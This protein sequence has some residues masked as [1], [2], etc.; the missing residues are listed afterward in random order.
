MYHLKS[1]LFII[2]LSFCIGAFAGIVKGKVTDAKT[3]EPL[4]G[5]TVTLTG[6]GKKLTTSVNLDGS[7]TFRNVP[8]GK[9]KVKINFAGYKSQEEVIAEVKSATDIVVAGAELKEDVN[10][11]G[12]VEVTGFKSKESEAFALSIEKHNDVVTNVMSA[13]TIELSPDVTVANSLQ[14]M[15]GVSFQSSRSGE[16]GRAI[17]RGMDQRYNT[18]L[19]NGIQIPSPDDR[20]R[21]VPMNLFPADILQR[22][23]VIKAL[24]PNM[25]G[26]AIGGVMNL[27]MKDAP[28]KE[29]FRIFAAGG[30]NTIYNSS[31]PF[32]SFATSEISLKSP[33]EINPHVNP[34]DSTFPYNN[35]KLSNKSQPI[36]LQTGLTYGNRYLN[37]KLGFVIS[38]SYQNLYRGTN[39]VLITQLN[40]KIIPNAY[41]IAGNVIENY[42]QFADV[43]LNTISTQQK[44]FA[45]NNK[46]DYII[47]SKNKIS[48]YNLY[49]A[50]DELQARVSIDTNLNSNHGALTYNT[51]TSLRKQSIYN[52]T[53]HGEHQLT[54]RVSLNWSFAY[55]YAKQQL[56]DL[57]GYSYTNYDSLYTIGHDKLTYN[58][59]TGIFKSM[60]R[61]WS[62]NTDQDLAGYVNLIVNR[63]IK[64]RNVEF[65]AGG[66]FRHKTRDNFYRTYSLG[67]SSKAQYLNID[68]ANFAF[69]INSGDAPAGNAGQAKN[70]S[71]TENVS[72]GYGQFKFMLMPDIQVVGGARIEFTDQKYATDLDTGSFGKTGHIYYYDILP[73]LHLKY[74]LQHGKS[75]RVSYFRSLVRPSFADLIPYYTP[76]T[77]TE[78]YDMQGNP[79]LK[80]TT[81]DNFDIRYEMYPKKGSDEILAGVFLKEIHNPTEITFS[82]ANITG[83]NSGTS[84]YIL[85]PSNVGDVTNA[86]LELMGTKYFGKFG[87][88][89][90]Y[91]YTHSAT[92]TPK[93][94]KAYNPTSQISSDTVY[95]KN[96]T[97]PLQGQAENIGNLSLLFK[98]HKFGLDAQLGYSYT[99]ERIQLVS[100]FYG[101]DTWESPFGQLDF[102]FTKKIIKGLEVYGKVINLTNA[103]TKFYVKKDY[104][105]TNT[106][107]YQ[108]N[109]KH[110]IVQTDE[111]KT[112]Y[113]L[114]IRF[115]L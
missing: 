76:A 86:G 93:T 69:G 91:T 11:L 4:I 107:H 74:D 9:Y 78:A 20:S 103:K 32:N 1:L 96:Q 113:L 111:F 24:T 38:L 77:E 52:S 3:G 14:R 81:A 28:N 5:A 33:Y 8:V 15:S 39:E 26:N 92:T 27:A 82:N 64:N 84:T 57:A 63:K 16:G 19:V 61:S 101:L 12:N 88:S 30:G 102:S 83:G 47:N 71:I 75:F 108:D 36:N 65:S 18:T 62:H 105:D 114:G 89:G 6:N 46:F 73:S 59:D 104:Y 49:V 45:L 43:Y 110:I 17:I 90:N 35:L 40:P 34:T 67:T 42:P 58:G 85:T 2:F 70:Y 80:H 54:S 87:I 13:K 98:D 48:L 55:S 95:V 99:G 66:M 112:S 97:R 56:P 7:Y 100:S 44:R 22:L 68:S 23:E 21:F 94:Y 25:E 50:M 60:T 41:G 106:I 79:L 37:K 72:A 109:S 51:R 115:K 31:H 10:D 29:E 53:L